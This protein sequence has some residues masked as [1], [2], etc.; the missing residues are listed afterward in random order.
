M[1]STTSDTSLRK[2]VKY[3]RLN[4]LLRI[5][6]FFYVFSQKHSEKSS[7]ESH[8]NLSIFVGS[9]CT[10][11]LTEAKTIKTIDRLEIEENGRKNVEFF[12]NI[13]CQTTPKKAEA[14]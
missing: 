14:F 13:S 11:L 1:L 9:S 10:L 3:W 4:E 12:S 8:H 7:Q 2:S 6:N 5:F